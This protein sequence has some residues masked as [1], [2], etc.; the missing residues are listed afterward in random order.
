MHPADATYSENLIFGLFFL[1]LVLHSVIYIRI[2][3]KE[4]Q[5]QEKKYKNKHLKLLRNFFVL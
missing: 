5:C 4:L 3:R 1:S 2:F